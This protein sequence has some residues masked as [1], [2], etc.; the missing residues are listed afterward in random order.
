[1]SLKEFVGYNPD[2]IKDHSYLAAEYDYASNGFK[3]LGQ[4]RNLVNSLTHIRTSNTKQRITIN[5][6]MN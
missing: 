2:I 6:K 3:I 4:D 5:F 1:M